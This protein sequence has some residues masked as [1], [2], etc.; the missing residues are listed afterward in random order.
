V[1]RG[2]PEEEF[3]LLREGHR[4][5]IQSWVDHGVDVLVI[6]D[7]PRAR[8][9]GPIPDCVASD[10]DPET[11]CAGPRIQW[12]L[13]D[14][15]VDAARIVASDRVTVADLTDH[16]CDASTCFGV[17][18]GVTAFYDDNHMTRTFAETL[19]PFLLPAVHDALS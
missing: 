2:T 7:T 9:F 18:G 1:H 5:V 10:P 11:N 4:D 19:A 17:I 8:G 6:R 13:P 12:L 3:A 16:F 15:V 14:P